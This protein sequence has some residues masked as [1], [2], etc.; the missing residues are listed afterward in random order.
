MLVRGYENGQ[1]SAREVLRHVM[2]WQHKRQQLS[3]LLSITLPSLCPTPEHR[4]GV[5][6]PSTCFLMVTPSRWPPSRPNPARSNFRRW[7]RRRRGTRRASSPVAVE[8]PT[9][10]ANRVTIQKPAADA[11]L[12]VALRGTPPVVET[13]RGLADGSGLRPG[14]RVLSVN[15]VSVTDTP[16]AVAKLVA[17]PAGAVVVAIEP[18]LR[19]EP[20]PG[21]P[22]GAWVEQ[23]YCGEGGDWQFLVWG[24]VCES[25]VREVYLAPDGRR[26][27]ENGKQV[28]SAGAAVAVA[29]TPRGRR[30]Q[31]TPRSQIVSPL[32]A[33]ATSGAAEVVFLQ[34]KIRPSTH[35]SRTA[36]P[37]AS[38]MTPAKRS[39]RTAFGP[40][41]RTGSPRGLA[42]S[43]SR[44]GFCWGRAARRPSRRRPRRGPPRRP[45]TSRGRGATPRAP[46]RESNITAPSSLHAIDATSARAMRDPR[47]LTR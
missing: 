29:P 10:V 34:A 22:G 33:T 30:E 20:P 43:T 31:A 44:G 11:K 2:R 32:Y 3:I 46:V 4:V 17:A 47:R 28:A 45:G 26:F 24:W 36:C 21:V 7:P 39:A 1:R 41:R 14:D 42:R 16:D 15:G 12:G 35:Q 8:V 25:D 27:L 9:L 38:S 40:R 19:K 37:C 13:V 23:K 18:G 6:V 5:L